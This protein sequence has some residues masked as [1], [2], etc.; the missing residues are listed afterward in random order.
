[1]LSKKCPEM[2]RKISGVRPAFSR[3]SFSAS[4]ANLLDANTQSS[5]H[6][7]VKGKITLPY[8]DCLKSPR[9]SSATDQMKDKRLLFG[10]AICVVAAKVPPIFSSSGEAARRS[11]RRPNF[12]KLDLTQWKFRTIC[13]WETRRRPARLS[14]SKLVRRTKAVRHRHCPP[15]IAHHYATTMC[16][17]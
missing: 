17:Q 6:N 10:M 3:A 11:R 7:T 13:R 14:P 9:S 1:M 16:H 12:C 15:L 2:R 5:C 4:T 8:S